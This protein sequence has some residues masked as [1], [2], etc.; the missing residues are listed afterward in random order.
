MSLIAKEK[1]API[2][3]SIYLNY[4]NSNQRLFSMLA[5]LALSAF[6]RTYS[7]ASSS[8]GVTLGLADKLLFLI[9]LRKLFKNKHDLTC[10]GDM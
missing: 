5:N 6:K 3:R 9:R 10:S 8:L 2:N 7:P 1:A 4:I